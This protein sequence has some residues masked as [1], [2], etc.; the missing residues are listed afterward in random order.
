MLPFS[1]LI[2][3]VVWVHNHVRDST[4]SFTFLARFFFDFS[5]TYVGAGMICSHL[6]NL[7]ILFGAVLSWGVIWPLIS[8]QKGNWYSAEASETSMTS[9]YGY[10]VCVV[11]VS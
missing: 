1:L 5:L 3:L 8:N 4:F 10:K 11:S 9:L 7:S 2:N 6:V